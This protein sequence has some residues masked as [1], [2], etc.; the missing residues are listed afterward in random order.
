VNR[1]IP[2]PGFAGDDGSADG[3]LCEALAA[4]AAG[5]AQQDAVLVA[6]ATS[7]LLVGVVA[8]LVG[9]ADTS[10]DG[11]RREKDTD[12]ALVTLTGT[13]GRRALPAFTSLDALR[14]WNPEARPVPVDA[15][16]VCLA[17][18]GEEADLVVIDPA[19]P[20]TY[21]LEGP[22]LRAI[23]GGR[24]PVPPLQDPDVAAAVRDAV[25]QE[26]AIAAA[27]LLPATAADCTVGL[28]VAPTFSE[29]SAAQVAQRIAGRLAADP[30][31]RERLDR[32]MEVAVFPTGTAPAGGVVLLARQP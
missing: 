6:L 27:Y 13:D 32:G 17:A 23:A 3:A 26:P 10:A 31:L 28:V 18:C 19:G 2:D 20:V 4:H 29:L 11:L 15:R 5:R 7:R 21:L 8:L 30:I 1:A 12:M 9:E 22:A 16:R 25:R 14:R 24:E